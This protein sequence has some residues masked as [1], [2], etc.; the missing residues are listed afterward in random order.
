MDFK[1][2]LKETIIQFYLTSVKFLKVGDNEDLK[3]YE[4]NLSSVLDYYLGRKD[5]TNDEIDTLLVLNLHL[6]GE[7]YHIMDGEKYGEY[8]IEQYRKWF[9]YYQKVHLVNSEINPDLFAI[10][11][12]KE[13]I[14]DILKDS[15]EE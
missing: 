12:V 5:T 9:D 2:S 13:E 10:N 8:T 7:G 11:K 4:E 15:N 1:N 14:I 6:S 3:T